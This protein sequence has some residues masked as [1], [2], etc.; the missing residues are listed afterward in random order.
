[1]EEL[2]NMWEDKYVV[3]KTRHKGIDGKNYY[4]DYEDKWGAVLYS[5]NH[6]GEIQRFYI[7]RSDYLK[8]IKQLPKGYPFGWKKIN[9]KNIYTK[10]YDEK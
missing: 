5:T 6:L 10:I 9:G 4:Y 3:K 7:D 1:M 2:K 8:A